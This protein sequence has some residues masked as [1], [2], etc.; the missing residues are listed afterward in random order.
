MWPDSK[1]LELI[2]ATGPQAL[3]VAISAGI[4]LLME[5]GGVFGAQDP[6]V[7][8][9]ASFL[10]LL[11]SSLVVIAAFRTMRLPERISRWRWRRKVSDEVRRYIPYMTPKE[12]EIIGYLLS[13]KMKTFLAASD[14]G[15]ANTLISR[16]IVIVA[17]RP[18]QS[19]EEE[20]VP[21]TIPDHIWK[22]LEEH[23]N[24]FP[25]YDVTDDR[26]KPWRISW[27]AR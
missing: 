6:W 22:I 19:F 21:M 23:R 7:R 3:A 17:L 12:R 2:K 27:M 8:P 9:A 1:L 25:K 5:V 4:F 14:G 13:F 10:L 16:G 26:P 24:E 11:S 18:G 15:Y 20:S